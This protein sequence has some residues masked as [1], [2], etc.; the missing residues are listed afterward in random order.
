M[1]NADICVGEVIGT[2]ILILFRRGS[3]RRR[4][5]RALQGSGLGVDRDRLRLGVRRAGGCLQRVLL[6]RRPTAAAVIHAAF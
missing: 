1:S 4:H 2:A 3:V 5:A 6:K